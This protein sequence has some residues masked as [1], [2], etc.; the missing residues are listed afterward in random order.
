[1]SISGGVAGGGRSVADGVGA[2]VLV[3]SGVADGPHACISVHMSIAAQTIKIL[4]IGFLS[5]A[6]SGAAALW[7]DFRSQ[8][9]LARKIHLEQWFNGR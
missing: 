9:M 1:M 2:A 3:G 5:L 7:T 4:F 8:G 6:G